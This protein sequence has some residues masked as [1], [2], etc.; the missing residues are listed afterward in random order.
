MR[1]FVIMMLMVMLFFGCS[2][3]EKP[4]AEQKSMTKEE[5]MTKQK[6]PVKTDRPTQIDPEKFVTTPSGLKYYDIVVGTG[7]TAKSGNIVE[8]HYTGWLTDG[9]RFDSSVLRGKPFSFPLGQGRV[10][11]GW[12]EGVA[13]MKV[14][15][16]RQLII[17]PELAYGKRGAANVIPPDATLIF[18][19]QLLGI[20]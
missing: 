20:K 16:I 11:R 18:E 8:V 15:G 13:G 4:T 3:N 6:A 2:K 12:D 5:T 19:V 7:E 10:I 1:S 14:G 9:K 17:P